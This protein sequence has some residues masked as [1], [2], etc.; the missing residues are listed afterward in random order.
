MYTTRLNSML[1][2]AVCASSTAF[3]ADKAAKLPVPAKKIAGGTL[4]WVESKPEMELLNAL[5]DI[6][7]IKKIGDEYETTLSFPFPPGELNDMAFKGEKLP[8]PKDVLLKSREKSV[9]RV[10]CGVK[11]MYAFAV[12]T[13]TETPDG[14]S[15]R[16]KTYDADKE[17]KATLADKYGTSSYGNDPRSLICWAMARKCAKEPFTWPPPKNKTPLEH[18]KKADDMRAAYAKKFFPTCK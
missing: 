12:K 17:R 13:W 7:Q 6:G 8:A 3:A 15:L 2:L 4:L 1:L 9:E 10:H 11:D 18:S 16:V 5:V 14:K